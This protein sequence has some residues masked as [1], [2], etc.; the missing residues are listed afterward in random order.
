[1]KPHLL[2]LENFCG[3]RSGLGKSEIQLDLRNIDSS[4]TL[5][6]LAG[7]N[8][9]GKTTLMDNLHPFRV[10]PF[11]ASSPSP[12]GFSYWDHIY[13]PEAAKH[14]EWE[15][16]GRTYRSDLVFRQS[17]KRQKQDAYL[18]VEQDGRWIPV[19]LPD[20]TVSDGKTNTYDACIEHLLGKPEVFFTAHYASQSRVP[21]S[22]MSASD[23]KS[24]LSS[25]LGH[26]AIR[27]EGAKASAVAKL[28]GAELSRVQAE[29]RQAQADAEQ[30]A[31]IREQVKDAD[32][33]L[34]DAK[35]RAEHAQESAT[36]AATAL[37]ALSAQRDAQ[38]SLRTQR[39]Q[40][41]EQI[42][43]AR[44]DLATQQTEAA[45]QTDARR[46]EIASTQA[47]A[48]QQLTGARSEA[49]RLQTDQSRRE[50]LIAQE[51]AIEQAYAQLSVIQ[52]T[53]TDL[54]AERS[55]LAPCVPALIQA[56]GAL[57]SAR[58]AHQ[59]TIA[60]GT[61]K[62]Q[63]VG[64][65]LATAKL[66]EE[67]PCAGQALQ[68]RCP[69]LAHANQA[70][71]N[72]PREIVVL[73]DLRKAFETER[74]QMVGLT[75]QLNALEGQ[76]QQLRDLDRRLAEANGHLL[77]LTKAAS[78]REALVAAKQE[79]PQA[80]ENLRALVALQE[81]LVT[82]VGETAARMTELDADLAIRQQALAATHVE[83]VRK[84][85]EMLLALP[86][87][88]DDTAH[89]QAQA[90]LS[91]A[92]QALSAARHAADTA[93]G[94]I[95]VLQVRA[96]AAE[97][98]ARSREIL[99]AQVA[100]LS[101]E[102]AYWQLLAKCL[103]NDGLIALSIDDA[104]PAISALCN[105][106]LEECYGGRFAVQFATQR[107]TQGGTQRE[108]FE[109]H[110]QDADRGETKLL[111]LMS[112]GERVWINDC[113]VRALAVHMAHGTG[114]GVQTLF[115]DEAD[116]PLDPDRK[117]QYMAMK[118]AVLSAGGYEREFFIS[119]TPELNAMADAIIDIPS[120]G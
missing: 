70:K 61:A 60:D 74:A 99:A 119:Q 10:M 5:V 21:L 43:A 1:M 20:G 114:G 18:T 26:D 102:Q 19:K 89:R 37:A 14:L 51:A 27:S 95:Q 41:E 57:G 92:Q 109:I 103:S 81:Q 45:R 6:A 66:I 40:L 107:T 16:H 47:A 13:G 65:M 59:K 62:R 68:G 22:G 110:V 12:G 108:T 36:T 33:G 85:E 17:G 69:L 49:Q 34:Q 31:I 100:A 24:L 84:L 90:T 25:M 93:Q 111:G 42:R 48:Q 58:E 28:L 4:A 77:S 53:V 83:Q 50:A 76:D 63:A 54:T 55:R 112:G 94:Q 73:Q 2:R 35:L 56:R 101:D 46:R 52:A 39:Q 29:L 15:H 32:R 23:T 64:T 113:L 38:A 30:A 71:A 87:P 44:A 9:T 104:G 96:A 72:L 3:I 118:R 88:V 79:A 105:H 78:Q 67:V 82:Q 80:A 7:P 75:E 97:Q 98:M 117:R 120:L 8:G 116:G 11:H 106:L 115:S 86:V 91:A